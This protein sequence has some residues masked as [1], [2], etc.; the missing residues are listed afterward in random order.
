MALAMTRPW[1]H[2]KTGVY[3]LRR[4]VPEKLQGIL[5][6]TEEKRSLGTKDP[7]EAKV[8]LSKEL[9][10]L[11]DKWVNLQKGPTVLT[12]SDA[13]RLALPFYERRLAAWKDNPRD[14]PAAWILEIGLEAVWGPPPLN[15][16]AHLIS[17][18]EQLPS[19][20]RIFLNYAD[21]VLTATGLTVDEKSRQ[22]LA[23]A[24]TAAIYRSGI[25]LREMALG[26][27]SHNHLAVAP[28]IA[29]LN[30]KVAER[31]KVPLSDLVQGWISERRPAKKTIY[32]WSRVTK[33]F[34]AYL[35]HAD[36]AR[37]TS[38]DLNNW[39]AKLIAEGR[40]PKTIRD[41]KIAPLRAILQWG[42][43]NDRIPANPAARVVL[44]VKVANNE[45]KRGFNNDEAALILRKANAFMHGFMH[46]HELPYC[47][48]P[49]DLAKYLCEWPINV[50]CQKI[51]RLA[52]MIREA[53]EEAG[54]F[55]PITVNK[56]LNALPPLPRPQRRR[57]RK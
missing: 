25:K 10:T 5:G 16:P 17:V 51:I 30:G 37:I 1:K 6:K 7:T 31:V 53:G 29:S 19:A 42:V 8:R 9:A 21:D 28:E 13:H 44:D 26:P 24:I 2:P 35:D 32:E 18:F 15:P 23:W 36:A 54:F 43:D 57:R 46:A 14:A 12:E 20:R 50:D 40:R 41:A 33:E 38:S 34:E 3:W 56:V 47:D 48:N 4:R 45:R 49:E 55:G 11:E 27:S 39:K 22:R 52:E